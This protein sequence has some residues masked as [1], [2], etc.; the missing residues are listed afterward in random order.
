M[1]PQVD[2]PCLSQTLRIEKHVCF[3]WLSTSLGCWVC[4]T[5]EITVLK[6]RGEK[7]LEDGSIFKKMV[8]FGILYDSILVSMQ[9]F[10]T[11]FDLVFTARDC[12]CQLVL[13]S[14]VSLGVNMIYSNTRLSFRKTMPKLM[15]QVPFCWE[16]CPISRNCSWFPAPRQSLTF[17]YNFNQSLKNVRFPKGSL[18]FW[19]GWINS[20]WESGWKFGK[21]SGKSLKFDKKRHMHS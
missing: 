7:S 21:V 16:P 13:S 6:E 2:L 4:F 11:I 9:W 8:D 15:G 10:A 19:E 18:E 20:L 3:S 12:G 17:S 14:I 5:Q 1:Q